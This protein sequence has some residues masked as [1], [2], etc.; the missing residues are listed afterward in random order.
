MDRFFPASSP[1]YKAHAHI[2]DYVFW[3][4]DIGA[5]DIGLCAAYASLARFV[6][7]EDLYLPP[8]DANELQSILRNYSDHIVNSLCSQVVSRVTLRSTNGYAVAREQSARSLRRALTTGD[9]L[10]RLVAMHS[11]PAV[12]PV[13]ATATLDVV[14]EH[15]FESSTFE[16]PRQIRSN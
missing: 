9:N 4:A 13:A 14:P 10:S 15:I 8:R 3:D 5:K 7:G 11:P 12:D 1:E 6:K 2:A 16:S